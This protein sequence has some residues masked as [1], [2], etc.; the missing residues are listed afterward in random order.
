MNISIVWF[1]HKNVTLNIFCFILYWIMLLLLL[2]CG[3]YRLLSLELAYC[4]SVPGSLLEALDSHLNVWSLDF[5]FVLL[6]DP[7]LWV[8]S[9]KSGQLGFP[10]RLSWAAEVSF[11]LQ[12][13][14]G[15]SGG[16]RMVTN[17]KR[18]E[19]C[20]AK[21]RFFYFPADF[22]QIRFVTSFQ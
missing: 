2:W 17:T 6:V 7:S 15:L 22:G 20:H 9:V 21:S 19:S 8:V 11:F 10:V 16:G 18:R 1:W 12:F 4:S 13:R 3:T 14:H 5:L